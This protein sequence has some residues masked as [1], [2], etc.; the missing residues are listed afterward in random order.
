MP[1]KEE[2]VEKI[3]NYIRSNLSGDLTLRSLEKRFQVGR[4]SLQRVFIEVM[5]M[6]PR[7][8][9]EQ[10]RIHALKGNL[11]NGKPL[12]EAIYSTGYASQ[13]WLYEDYLSKLAM[14]PSSYR[15][16]GEGASIRFLTSECRLGFLLVAETDYGIC[17]VSI[18]D[19]ELQLETALIREYP[20]AVITRSESARKS[21]D[22]VLSYFDGQLLNLPMDISGTEFQ[23]RVWAAIMAIPYGE[24][25]SYNEVAAT[26]G[27]PKAYRAVANACASNPIPLII[28]CHRVIR[29]NGELGGYG[30]GA[31]RKKYLLD[32]EKKRSPGNARRGDR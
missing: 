21:L 10:C 16:G 29:N 11:R 12:P 30:M 24:T 2:L 18:A 8:Y 5:G 13:S 25:R 4:Y 1:T 9:A 26:V 14:S 22:S 32:M 15:K 6:S 20:R 7:Q 17:S 28:P 3:C 27:K 19:D 23:K 31:R